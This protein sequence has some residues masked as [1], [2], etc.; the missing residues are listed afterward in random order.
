[1][2]KLES[3]RKQLDEVWI[4]INKVSIER[5]DT[6]YRRS[7][8]YFGTTKAN[9]TGLI[10]IESHARTRHLNT[11]ICLHPEHK[12][13]SEKL[14]EI[15]AAIKN[16]VARLDK[17]S[18]K[19]WAKDSIEKCKNF[20]QWQIKD[21]TINTNYVKI[22]IEGN[23]HIYACHPYY[24]HEDY[25]KFMAMPNTAKHRAI[26]QELNEQMIHAGLTI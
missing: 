14:I 15:K 26:A 22:F 17:I 25:N 13:L 3:L 2:K 12:Y 9:T 24:K 8:G 21:G 6:S 19:K 23:R 11:Y 10:V 1:M 5:K 16:E 18:A 7:G 4:E 20:V